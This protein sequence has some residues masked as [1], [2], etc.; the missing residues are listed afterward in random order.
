LN[1]E[2]ALLNSSIDGANLPL[3][4]ANIS[5]HRTQCSQYLSISSIIKWKRGSSL[6]RGSCCMLIILS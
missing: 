5:L 1:I 6:R 4:R 2:L 3:N